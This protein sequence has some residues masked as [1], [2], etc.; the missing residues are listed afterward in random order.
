MT[1]LDSLYAW[2]FTTLSSPLD[3]GGS[4]FAFPVTAI[5][6]LLA[7][8]TALRLVLPVLLRYVLMLADAVTVLIGVLLLG[9]D[10]LLASLFRLCRLR[11]PAI[12]YGL[13][14]TLVT[15]TRAAQSS[16]TMLRTR[17]VRLR[18]LSGGLILLL[19]LALVWWWDSGYCGRVPSAGCTGPMSAWLQ[20]VMP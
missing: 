1:A 12:V 15:A 10:F 18:G 7:A 6:V 20:L 4:L 13:G 2:L 3:D 9:V 17:T 11:P 19:V 5:G 16:L 8:R 14:D